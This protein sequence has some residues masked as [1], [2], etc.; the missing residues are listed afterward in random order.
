MHS[1][2]DIL[3]H[4]YLGTPVALAAVVNPWWVD[5]I[6]IAMPIVLQVL[7]AAFLTLQVYYIIKNKGKE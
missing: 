5:I 2:N 7:G 6:G 4:P 3:S 1:M